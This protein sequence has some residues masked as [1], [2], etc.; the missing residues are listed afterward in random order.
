MKSSAC[1]L[2]LRVL[3]IGLFFRHVRLRECKNKRRI[4]IITIKSVRVRLRECPAAG[5]YKYRVL[6]RVQTGFWKGVH[7]WSCPLTRVSAQRESTVYRFALK[8]LSVFLS[9]VCEYRIYLTS[10]FEQV[11]S[12]FYVTPLLLL[13]WTLHS[14][15]Y[16]F[17][18]V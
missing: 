13:L 6:L 17:V 9:F 3:V 16:C 4:Q 10:V 14:L 1:E 11:N 7:I 18:Y 2:G 8:R 15:F 5:T 12:M